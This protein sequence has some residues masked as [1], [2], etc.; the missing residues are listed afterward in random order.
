MPMCRCM[1][2]DHVH[3]RRACSLGVM[4]IRQA[5]GE[6]GSEMEERRGRLVEHASVAVGRSRD[7]VFL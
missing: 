5:V 6:S 3:D 7:H 4:E 2:A 1:V